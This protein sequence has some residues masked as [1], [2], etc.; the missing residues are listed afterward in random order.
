MNDKV[1]KFLLEALRWG[2]L[3]FVSSVINFA[4]ENVAGLELDP[5]FTLLLTST[6]RFVDAGLHKSG[7]AEKGIL[8]F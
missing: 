3:G 4:L 7:V 1:K 6:L 5:S 2:V 8:R